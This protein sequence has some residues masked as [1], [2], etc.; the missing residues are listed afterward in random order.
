MQEQKSF[1]YLPD[2]S[3]YR[4]KIFLFYLFYIFFKYH[5]LIYI[6]DLSWYRYTVLK[7]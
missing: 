1:I 6:P 7:P 5:L 2:L 4:Y 3:W